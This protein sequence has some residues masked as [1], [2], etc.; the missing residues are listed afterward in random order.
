MQ[1]T[2]N[3]AYETTPSDILSSNIIAKDK[4]LSTRCAAQKTMTRSQRLENK[5]HHDKDF[6]ADAY[7]KEDELSCR[8][9]HS[10]ATFTFWKDIIIAIW[11][12]TP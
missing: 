9:T 4:S 6:D 2:M 5:G 10:E 12:T 1:T 7:N 11:A 8:S 3:I